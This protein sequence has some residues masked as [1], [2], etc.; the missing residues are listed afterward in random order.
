M[1]AELAHRRSQQAEMYGDSIDVLAQKAHQLMGV[2][3]PDLAEVVGLSLPM[4]TKLVNGERVRIGNTIAMGRIVQLQE[5]ADQLITGQASSD[6]IA[7]TLAQIRASTTPARSSKLT[8]QARPGAP[9]DNE[10]LAP[11]P[12]ASQESTVRRKPLLAPA[13]GERPSITP[14]SLAYARQV[15][16]R[17]VPTTPAY[18]WPLLERFTQTETWV[19]H[20]NHGPTGAF[21]VRGG[22][23]FLERMRVSGIP[24]PAGLVAATAGNHGQS[25]AFAGAKSGI[26]VTIVVA[27]QHNPDQVDCMEGFGAEVV[28]HGKD[29]QEARE[30]AAGLAIDRGL[31]N[32]PA[33]HAWLVEGV[34]TYVAEFHEQVPSLDTI[35]VPIGM[36][37]GA[38]AHI[39]VR[40]ILGLRTEIVGVVAAGAP[41]YA[42]S[43]EQRRPVS[44]EAADTFVDGVACRTPDPIAVDVIN[45]GV[46]RIVRVEEDEAAEAMGLVHRTTHNI[47][48]P[49]GALALAGL[50]AD[51]TRATG[52]RVGLV[53][54][55]GNADL[56][57]LTRIF[58]ELG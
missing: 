51:R 48:E 26:P 22:L 18:R 10:R 6:D 39:L 55:G 42:L 8:A 45:R 35:Y 4:M 36:G 7:L 23:N 21:K 33:F 30:Y 14:N 20:E 52:K 15:V 12:R 57:T 9:G 16:G 5:F 56:A 34:A 38:C 50:L 27:E 29:F 47:A 28:V 31:L 19:K 25:L 54:T 43:F 49:A 1:D 32:I 44:T 37:S 13:T 11:N 53:L 41:A 24:M 17:H 40:D 3:L 58:E 2:A 46:S